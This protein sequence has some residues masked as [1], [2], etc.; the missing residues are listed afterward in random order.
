MIYAGSRF[1]DKIP[2]EL[3]YFIRSYSIEINLTELLAQ[4]FKK[5]IIMLDFMKKSFQYNQFFYP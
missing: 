5:N 3:V 2:L 4:V 1:Y